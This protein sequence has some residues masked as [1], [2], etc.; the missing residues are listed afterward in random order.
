[1]IQELATLGGY[2]QE[3]ENCRK[4]YCSR[5]QDDFDREGSSHRDRDALS[6]L[7]LSNPTMSLSGG[8]APLIVLRPNN[9]DV[10]GEQGR[11]VEVQWGVVYH[12]DEGPRFAVY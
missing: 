4:I 3:V 5:A 11:C 2:W 8:W 10:D 9:C 12:V 1:M 6:G 7:D